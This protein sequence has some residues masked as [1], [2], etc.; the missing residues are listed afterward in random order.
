MRPKMT[1][2]LLITP[3]TDQPPRGGRAMLSALHE[4]ALR[5][6]AGGGFAKLAL[7]PAPPSGM[8]GAVAALRGAVDGVTRI[9]ERDIAE[10]VAREGIATV[11]LDGSNLGRLARAIKARAPA[12]RV[13]TLFHNVEARFF[14]G[15]L[16]QA[17]SA[18]AVAVLV[19]NFAA[20][21]LAMRFSDR[22]IALNTRDSE[23]LAALYGRAATDIVPLAVADTRNPTPA[24]T[25][26]PFA[27]DYLL[28]VGGGF[29]ANL[30]GIAWFARHVAP[31]I[32]PAFCVIG[33][34][35]E[36]LRGEVDRHPNVHLVGPVD[37]LDPWYRH[38][39][40]VVA[41][42]FDGS[43]MKT[44]VAEALMHGKTIAGTSEAFTGYEACGAIGG[45]CDD[46]AAFVAAIAE[47]GAKGTP[48][49]DPALRSL[50]EQ[51]YSPAALRRALAAIIA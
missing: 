16:R 35:L 2:L 25:T 18:R 41:P 10:R 32:D 26:P 4:A 7:P 14:L 48:S 1:T 45:R 9:S 17:K 27:T 46:A 51:H 12:T 22:R 24:S 19:A 11:Y 36:G 44:K 50:Y 34:G 31:H 43:G 39:R 38:A 42:I 13:I 3:L 5:D 29:Y 49:F 37:D 21:R 20:E 47:A 33:R 23:A 6:I 8:R 15:A 40:L 28:F 30:A